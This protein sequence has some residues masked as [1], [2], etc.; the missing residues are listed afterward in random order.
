MIDQ[1]D[2]QEEMYC[3]DATIGE[4]YLEN[5]SS[6]TETDVLYRILG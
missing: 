4:R 2:L 6:I 5:D 1:L 3:L